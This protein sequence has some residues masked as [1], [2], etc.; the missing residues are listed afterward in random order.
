MPRKIY[1]RL[2]NISYSRPSGTNEERKALDYLASEIRNIGFEPEF[3][4]FIYKRKVPVEAT[5][6]AIDDEG[7]EISFPVTGVVDSKETSEAGETASFYYL[8]SFDEVALTRIRGK[9][10]LIHDRLSAQEYKRL[11]DA[12]VVAIIT[13]SGTVRDTYENSDLETVRFRDNLSDFEPVPSF[14]IRLIDAVALLRLKPTKVR[15]KLILK[16]EE[17]KSRNLLVTVE[18]STYADEILTVGAHYDSVPFSLGSWDNGAG[19]VQ[20]ISLLE[21]LKDNP[22]KRTVRVILFGSEETGLRGSRAYTQD[23]E[24]ALAKTRA[25]INV[26]VGGSI[27]GKEL[28]FI[29]ASDET[30]IWVRQLLKEIGY[31]A[32]TVKKLMSSDSANFNDVGIPSISIGQGAP[33]GGG[34]MHTRY[35]N[36]D[37]IDEDV[38]EREAGFLIALVKRLSDAEVFPIPRFI[39]EG[40]RKEIIDYFGN[41]KNRISTIPSGEEPKPL[42]F[43]F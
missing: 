9:I 11:I 4:E 18:G 2:E 24:E 5:I 22:V 25:M 42:P 32:V 33:R 20:M 3:Q 36:M 12:G 26:D 7:K 43:H 29:G 41:G 8:K 35:D 34:Y 6:A 1:E 17:V 40:L 23:N 21:H 14:T 19:A 39:P 30:E 38:L 10:V 31:E 37:L 28:I 16:E 13:S 15:Y 27:L